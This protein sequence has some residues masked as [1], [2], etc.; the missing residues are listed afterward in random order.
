MKYLFSITLFAVLF[1]F[2]SPSYSQQYVLVGW[3]DLGMHCANKDFSMIA[4]LPPYNNMHAQ[5][6]LKSPTGDPQVV[7]S[8][9]TI[10]YSIPGNTYSV[11]KTNFWDYAQQLFNLPTPLPLNVGLT[12]NGLTGSLLPSGNFFV[13]T[14]IPITPYTD[15]NLVTENPYQLIHLVAKAVG[16]STILA[17]TDVVIPVSNEISCV[18]SG[19]HSSQQ[20][21]LDEH[22]NE[23]GFNKNGPNLC[24]NCH[25]DNALGTT[26]DP[27]AGIFSEVI[28]DKHKNMLPQNEIST[29]YKCHPG[30]NTQ[31]L[32]DVMGK[33]PVN[34]MTCQ[35]CHGTMG[36]V[37]SSI[38]NG[39]RPWLDEPSC[40]NP[41]CHGSNYA[42]EPGKL[43]R[44]SQG[45]GGL[46]CS[47]CHGSPHAILPTIQANDN[48]QNITLQG[49]AGTLKECT[50]CHETTPNGP[51]P[52][53]I[54]ATNNVTASL[55]LTPTSGNGIFDINYSTTNNES[56]AMTYD[57]W[58]TQKSPNG[59]TK[60]ILNKNITL[61]AGQTFSRVKHADISA[62]PM[63]SYTY[64]L[65][66][67]VNPSTVWHSD[68][69]IYSKTSASLNSELALDDNSLDEEATFVDQT[70]NYPNPFNPTTT[71][72]YSVPFQGKVK[73]TIFDELGRNIRE[74][75]NESKETGTYQ[76]QFDASGLP[77]GIYY[78]TV[79]A[80]AVNG[81]ENYRK[82]N[83]M[84]YLK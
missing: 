48:L 15:A 51:G 67:G 29:C 14:G 45:H 27:E 63:G 31:C 68:I 13:A 6:I 46:N 8:G 42:E 57:V 26:G 47:A 52:H 35:N 61:N 7:T 18:S 2:I 43:F 39:R 56:A 50:V 80:I 60:Q 11:G 12:G 40:G 1:I 74:V 41:L 76:V 83:K 20:D 81:G 4:V 75:V 24:A 3:N 59:R 33:D 28:H 66:V 10:E 62:K 71:I 30:E 53:G 5:L 79:E 55:T 23:P 16:S 36:E 34:P 17:T 78:Y 21:I 44:E 77:S 70:A 9:Y 72:Q 49:Y 38:S 64:T 65:N 69:K 58:I 54:M 73:L 25:A 19:C 32:R 84:I 82:V 37:A 22:E